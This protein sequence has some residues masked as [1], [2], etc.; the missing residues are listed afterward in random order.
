MSNPIESKGC[1]ALSI[2]QPWAWLI[3]NGYKDI[4]NRDWKTHYRGRFYVHAGK[5]FD[6]AGYAD[7]QRYFPKSCCRTFTSLRAV[8]SSA[9]SRSSIAW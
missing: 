8:A 4:E 5:Q 3:V 6:K 1:I 7:V 2:R 9:R